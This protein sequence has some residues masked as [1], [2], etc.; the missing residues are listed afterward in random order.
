MTENSSSEITTLRTLTISESVFNQLDRE[1]KRSRL[2]PQ[3]LAERLL[4]ERLSADEQAWRTQF[5][6][7]LA[8]VRARMTG[9]APN[10]IEAD[11]TAASSE[12]KAKRR[13][14]RRSR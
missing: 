11:I 13:A 1:A 9:F 10:Q 7:L 4:A 3:A 8:R 2:S 6:S 12:A 14:H 5:E